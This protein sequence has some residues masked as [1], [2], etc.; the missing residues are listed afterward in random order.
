MWSICGIHDQVFYLNFVFC[1]LN[2]VELAS[3]GRSGVS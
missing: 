1:F 2:L 3:G